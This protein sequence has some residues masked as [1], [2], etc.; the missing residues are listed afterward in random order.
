MVFMSSISPDDDNLTPVKVLTV[1]ELCRPVSVLPVP[2]ENTN[3]ILVC[4]ETAEHGLTW[5]LC[6]HQLDCAA[7]A[8][9]EKPTELY[10]LRSVRQLAADGYGKYVALKADG[11]VDV[12]DSSFAFL[13]NSLSDS[14]TAKMVLDLSAGRLAAAGTEQLRI[15][16]CIRTRERIVIN[17]RQWT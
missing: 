13:Q 3:G 17:L 5:F 1:D 15:Y 16:R 7:A 6:G 4:D 14:E 10:S 12:L 8:E 9:L 2:G 11:V